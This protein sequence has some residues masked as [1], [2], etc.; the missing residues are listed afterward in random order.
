MRRG[1][2]RSVLVGRMV[3]S[4]TFWGLGGVVRRV[5][6]EGRV[7]RAVGRGGWGRGAVE[8]GQGRGGHLGR[9]VGGGA[10]TNGVSKR[11][12][13]LQGCAGVV[14]GCAGGCAAAIPEF[15]F[16]SLLCFCMFFVSISTYY[17]SNK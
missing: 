8:G 14:R 9:G 3:I 2:R 5:V 6:R 7:R 1:V 15:V 16:K 12:V 17:R 10:P 11:G 13:K 4:G